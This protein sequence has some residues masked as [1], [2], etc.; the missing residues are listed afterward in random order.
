M[1]L[2]LDES[3]ALN[4]LAHRCHWVSPD[5]TVTSLSC[6]GEGNMN[7]VLRGQL[8][9]GGSLIFKQSLP[10]VARYPQ[11][12]APIER[13]Q[14]E[15][16][17]YE[18]I[19]PIPELAQST[20]HIH[21]FDAASNILCMSDLGP[22]AD[23]LFVY[24]HQTDFAVL[25]PTLATL[26]QWLSRLHAVPIS[27]TDE[28][29]LSNQKMRQL[30]HEHIFDLPWRPDNGLEYSHK[31]ADSAK[32]LQHD[33]G[34]RAVVSRLGDIYLGR[35]ETD[36]GRRLLHGDF[37]PGSWVRDTDDRVVIIDPEFCF[38]GA[39]EFDVGVF[40]GHLT[41]AGFLQ[42]DIQDLLASYSPP[43][44]FSATLTRQFAA[45]EVIRRILGVA[46]L[47]LSVDDDQ[48]VEWLTWAAAMLQTGSPV[49]AD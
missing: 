49:A 19:Q 28:T 12:A 32:T 20:P 45:A 23:Y 13:L 33:E 47:P 16:L 15:A 26:L 35:C 27:A 29:R 2:A 24:Q 6:A 38:C 17:F 43:P 18:T 14:S 22:A 46:Q 21:G 11:I 39:A 10:F 8:S 30:N 42:S 40:C 25:R 9:S 4:E 7:V 3:T 31:V 48:L 41:F 44:G 34:L 1:K 36:S 5:T 37:Y